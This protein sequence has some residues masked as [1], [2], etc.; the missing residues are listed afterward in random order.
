M[1]NHT[2][3]KTLKDNWLQWCE[4]SSIFIIS[5]LL[6]EKSKSRRFL[7]VIFFIIGIFCCIYVTTVSLIDYFKYKTTVSIHHFQDRE[8]ILPAITIC[9]MNPYKIDRI[10]E[11]FG[12]NPIGNKK[13]DA[14]I[15]TAKKNWHTKC[16]KDNETMD[17]NYYIRS[18]KGVLENNQSLALNRSKYSYNLKND[19]FISCLYNLKSCTANNFTEFW[20]R[21][22]G[23]CYIK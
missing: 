11:F 10:G 23:N 22:F 6:L 18:F 13:Y 5:K 4:K 19:M 14:C 21:Q 20:S 1:A 9:N 3:E 15:K 8:T 12:H 16:F 2:L 7:C 17:L